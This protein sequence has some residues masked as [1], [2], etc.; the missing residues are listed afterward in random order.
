MNIE[1]NGELCAGC[2]LCVKICPPRILYMDEGTARVKSKCSLTCGHCEAICP[3]GA[4]TVHGLDAE[5]LKLSTVDGG[6]EWLDYGDFDLKTL[7]RLMRSRRSCRTFTGQPVNRDIL[8]DL[9]RIGITAPSGSNAQHWTFTILDNRA[10]VIKLAEGIARLMMRL[11]SMAESSCLRFFSRIFMKDKLGKYYREYYAV[12]KEGLREWEEN[13]TDRLFFGAPAVIVVGMKKGAS[14]PCEDALLASQNI[15]LAAHAMGLGTCLIGF[16]VEAMNR[17]AAIKETIGI[18][19]D[20]L[21]YAVIA[22]GV[23]GEKFARQ[24]RRKKPVIRYGK[25][26]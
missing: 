3:E 21:V 14:C 24:A 10:D 13:G 5:A 17:D 7:V 1:I 18:P 12:V 8:E 25:D 2:G 26:R 23:P 15:L 11:N 4:V 9:V 20:E 6:D 16:A 19:R 22:V